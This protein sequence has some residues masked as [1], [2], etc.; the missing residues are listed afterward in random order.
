MSPSLIY[1]LGR[2]DVYDPYI[3]SDPSAAKAPGGSVW[4]TLGEAQTYLIAHSNPYRDLSWFAIYGV[5]ADWE[6]DTVEDTE[7]PGANWRALNRAAYLVSL[8]PL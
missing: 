6:R 1:T 4:R 5:V 7:T 2:R 3:A 8:R